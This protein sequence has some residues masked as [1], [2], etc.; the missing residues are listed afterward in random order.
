MLHI[1]C[2]LYKNHL[3]DSSYTNPYVYGLKTLIFSYY[4][5]KFNSR[6]GT[7]I[8]I[9]FAFPGTNQCLDVLHSQLPAKSV[10]RTSPLLFN[11]FHN[12]ISKTRFWKMPIIPLLGFTF[13]MPDHPLNIFVQRTINDY[14]ANVCDIFLKAR[15]I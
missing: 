6:L 8:R 7:T 13:W 5:L 9:T 14:D 11:Y 10:E 1:I 4:L 12:Q 2:T 15:L 3:L